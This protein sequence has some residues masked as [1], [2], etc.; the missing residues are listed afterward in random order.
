MALTE[1]NRMKI[2]YHYANRSRLR[3]DAAEYKERYVV[4]VWQMS[5]WAEGADVRTYVQYSTG[6]DLVPSDEVSVIT[7]HTVVPADYTLGQPP[8][9]MALGG[10][11][12]CLW[13]GDLFD[14]AEGRETHEG[15]CFGG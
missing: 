7:A 2:A 6:V 12:C 11:C 5:P 9:G 1:A 3:W 14:D 13:C 4:N 10:D 8:R 15:N